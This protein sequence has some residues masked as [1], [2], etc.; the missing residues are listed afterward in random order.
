M[1]GRV[2]GIAL[3]KKS[4]APMEL[5]PSGFISESEGLRGDFRG[6]AGNRQVTVLFKSAW[7][8]ACSD[9]GEDLPWSV[10]RANVLIGGIEFQLNDRSK[11]PSGQ[12]RIKIGDVILQ[13]TGETDP[14]AR[15][16]EQH[17]GLTKALTPDWRGGVCCRV[18]V[19]GRIEIGMPASLF[20]VDK[21]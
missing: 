11:V 15:M 19:G 2:H 17:A 8:I 4:R 10:R 16:D 13:V 5:I 6:T 1:G 3:R 12:L 20:L 18:L 7:D 21:E 9:L 14:C